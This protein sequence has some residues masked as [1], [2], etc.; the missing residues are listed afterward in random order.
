MTAR[1]L[2]PALV[3]TML[4]TAPAPLP[5]HPHIFIDTDFE[6]ILD[7]DGQARAVRVAWSYDEFYSLLLI[8][9][10]GLD[11]DRDGLPEPEK[12]AEYAGQDVDWDAGF[13][14]DFV[15]AADGAAVALARPVDHAARFE[16][17]RIVTSHVRPLETPIDVSAHRVTAQSYDPSYFVAYD[18]PT[19]PQVSGMPG[20]SFAREPAD[21][22]A[23]QAEYGD[24][25]A[26][27]D[28]GDDP[29]EEID[30]PDIGVMFADTFT[31]SCSA[32][33]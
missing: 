7:E 24:Q 17:G 4:A 30:L 11:A 18:V 14:G 33:S 3:A 2:L 10:N 5:A 9:E 26:A 23:A 32:S 1:I 8:E 22:A 12:L 21:H 28:A 27:I 15:I 16:D 29:F 25:L 31:L 20:C 13:P 6:L 19:P